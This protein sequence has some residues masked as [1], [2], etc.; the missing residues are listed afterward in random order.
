[1][2]WKVLTSTVIFGVTA[3]LTACGGGGSG[4]GSSSG[5]SN[6]D[7]APAGSTVQ[8]SAAKGIIQGGVVTAV[9][10]DSSGN[11]L[12]QVGSAITE[13]DGNYSLVLNNDYAGGV[14]KLTVTTTPETRMVCD[15]FD[16]C[17]TGINF[18]DLFE[19][20]AA[21][22]M[23]AVVPPSSTGSTVTSQITPL[24]HMAAARALAQ[25][26][27]NA[28]AVVNSISEINQLV[29]VNIQ[30][31]PVVD[32][33]SGAAL[34]SANNKSK[35]LSLFNAGL[36]EV[37]FAGGDINAGLSNLAQSFEDGVFDSEDDLSIE[38]IIQSVASATNNAAAIP[39]ISAQLEET[40]D[41]MVQLVSV[42]ESQIENGE[43]NPEPSSNANA[44]EVE[45]A[46]ALLTDARSF[47]ETVAENYDDPLE[48][49]ALDAD[50]V[51]S[52]FSSESEMNFRLVGEVLDQVLT[53]L[54]EDYQVDLLQELETPSLYEIPV[55][56]EQ[57]DSVGTIAAQFLSSG[58]GFSLQLVGVVAGTSDIA[59]SLQLGTN[60]TEADLEVADGVVSAFTADDVML[61]LAGVVADDVS[62]ITLNNVELELELLS[63]T[64]IDLGSEASVQQ[65]V[66]NIN[67]FSISGD[68]DIVVQG[69]SFGGQVELEL[70]PLDG[71]VAEESEI[72]LSLFSLQGDFN[73][74]DGKFFEA[75]AGLTINNAR[76]FDLFG[77]LESLDTING[78]VESDPGFDPYVQAFLD[79][80]EA[81]NPALQIDR[82]HYSLYY[83]Y[84]TIYFYGTDLLTNDYVSLE[85]S[86]GSELDFSDD[87][88]ALAYDAVSEYYDFKSGSTFDLNWATFENYG[89]YYVYAAF[90]YTIEPA[91][92][93]SLD[94]FLDA[95]ITI[96]SQVDDPQLPPADI[97]FS[98]ARNAY[99]GGDALLSLSHGGETYTIDAEVDGF[100][101][102]GEGLVTLSNADG[103][104]IV[105][106]LSDGGTT[107]VARVDGKEVG[108]ITTTKDDITLIRYNDGTFESLF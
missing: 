21:F 29:G 72:S 85:L 89:P 4:G 23:N 79:A 64:F 31:T 80:Y 108:E 10:L 96:S 103:V 11:E 67:S 68:M 33:T 65:G 55:V 105:L 87:L 91:E 58:N 73:S 71:G 97:T 26:E 14:L 17:G 107:G 3:F 41:D 8:G 88:Y 56:S 45:K 43:Y 38:T 28:A 24:S 106:Q 13:S 2:R 25:P 59:I 70:V 48:A 40:L 16:G 19:L 95:Q 101:Q 90:G 83:Y 34:S 36:A 82:M 75:S 7:P 5:G 78:Y 84:E 66:D 93:E 62:Q 50:T 69:N 32:I 98:V 12:A 35:Q 51:G 30:T 74:A 60:L 102:N 15:V 42:I 44:T 53:A 1:M 94:N 37:V 18:G 104:E 54:D 63:S 100:D 46:K 76:Q 22:E 47:L 39:E 92:F 52:I 99:D 9:E 49:L 27:V 57:G 81:Q 6:P 20:P 61:S 77:Y 86:K